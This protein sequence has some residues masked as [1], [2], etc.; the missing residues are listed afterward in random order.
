VEELTPEQETTIRRMATF[1]DTLTDKLGKR[2]GEPEPEDD[3]ASPAGAAVRV[4]TTVLKA[5]RT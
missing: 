2:S 5:E 3:V 1:L 4:A